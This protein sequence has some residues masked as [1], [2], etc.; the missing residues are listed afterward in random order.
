M[1]RI[2]PPRM[3]I[4]RF[5]IMILG[6]NDRLKTLNNGLEVQVSLIFFIQYDTSKAD[7][8]FKKTASNAKLHRYHPDFKF[9]PFKQGWTTS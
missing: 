8:Q 1:C 3:P 4:F 5:N 9:T 6:P 2:S 7:G